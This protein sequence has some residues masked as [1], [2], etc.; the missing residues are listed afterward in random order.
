MSALWSLPGVALVLSIVLL[1][2]TLLNLP[3]GQNLSP[4]SRWSFIL[5]STSGILTSATS[6]YRFAAISGGALSFTAIVL[7]SVS[8]FCL[9]RAPKPGQ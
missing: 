8:L 7:S 5:L 2:A 4:W 1:V 6:L 3:P 9:F